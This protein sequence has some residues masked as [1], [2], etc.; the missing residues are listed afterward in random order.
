MSNDI[1]DIIALLDGR[2]ELIDEVKQAPFELRRF[3]SD[4]FTALLRQSA[5]QDVIQSTAQD[6]DREILIHERLKTLIEWGV[7][8]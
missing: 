3:V 7:S 8:A 1:E 2:E 6:A 5:F 4:Q